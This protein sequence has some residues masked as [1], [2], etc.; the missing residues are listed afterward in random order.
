MKLL[1]V[2]FSAAS[3]NVSRIM[4]KYALSTLFSNIFILWTSL[5]VRD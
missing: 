2:Q 3:F 5:W 1:I 4:S